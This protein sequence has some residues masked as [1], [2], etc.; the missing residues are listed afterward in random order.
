MGL[1]R[2]CSEVTTELQRSY[3]EVAAELEFS[4]GANTNKK[5]YFMYLKS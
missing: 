3:S 4:N 2:S 1:Q 5:K